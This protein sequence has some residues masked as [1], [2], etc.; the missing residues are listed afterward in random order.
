MAK[1]KKPVKRL[2]VSSLEE[3]AI[4][5]ALATMKPISAYDNLFS[6][7]FARAKADWL[8]GMN[9]SRLFSCRYGGKLNVGRVQTP[10]LAMIV[11]RDNDVDDFVKQKY[12]TADL[13]CGGFTLSSAR[14]DDENIT[15]TLVSNCNGNTVTISSVKCEVKTE[16]APKLYDLTT[17]QRDANKAYGY[18]AQQ[19]LD[20]TQS[21]YESKLVTYPR[22]DSQF[23]SDD[24]AQTAFEV[25]MACRAVFDLGGE[26]EP[27]FNVIINNSKVSGHHAI[28][29]TVN[30]K[31]ADIG[32]LPSGEHNILKLIATRLICATAPV[33]KYESVKIIANCADT[34]FT[35]SGKTVLEPGWKQF[36]KP[37]KKEEKTIPAISEGQ[38]FTANTSKSE[39]LTSPP[40]AYTE[41][42][43]LSAMERAGNENYNDDTEKKGL[44]TPATR[45][46]VIES[47]VKNGYAKREGKN[48]RA[49][50][51]GKELITVVP[52][53]V[54]SAKLTAEW[55]NHLHMIEQG[56]YSADSY[57]SDIS[58]F[59][60]DMCRKYGSAVQ[61][62]NLTEQGHK[63]VGKCPHCGGEVLNGKYGIYCKN[64]CG[65]N[66]TKVYGVQLS[67][68]KVLDL[69]NG[70]QTSYTKNGRKTVVLPECVENPWNGKMYYQW[71]TEKG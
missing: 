20:Y 61:S 3:S 64:K 2:W 42:T 29:P 56:N 53:E 35:A 44:G 68:E 47:L 45:A 10:T 25:E 54:K 6:A 67:D 22:T 63:P 16:K 48:I 60:T 32:N 7:G 65:M 12:F 30:I 51:K 58:V 41:D 9:G 4:K 36:V 17:L 37:D 13:D 49:T 11:K 19:T 40:K 28:I 26:Y 14:I 70:K 34:E 5:S 62:A 52:D 43:L 33:H 50:D 71:K 1:C 24:M 69:L 8:V 39:H 23:L 59:I 46:A 15:D 18:T 21:L 31:T 27:N 66:L 38:T 57:M 55:E